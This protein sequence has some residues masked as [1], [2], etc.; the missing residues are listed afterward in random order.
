MKHRLL[1]ILIAFD[2][3]L[4]TIFCGGWADETMS[5]N[6]YRMNVAGK[7]WGFM[8]WVIDFL[9]FPIER[10]HCRKS[11]QAELMRMQSPPGDRPR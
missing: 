10:D 5:S 6:A 8:R 3:L 9:F 1:Q 2:Q 11:H 4:N 7:P